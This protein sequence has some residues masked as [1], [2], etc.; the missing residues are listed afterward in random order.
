M[1]G[2][3]AYVKFFHIPKVEDDGVNVGWFEDQQYEDG[4]PVAKVARW[5]EFG[6]KAGIPERPFMRKTIMRHEKEWI[7][8][9]R[10][11]IQREI[12]KKKGTNIDRALAQFGEE[13]KG[14]IQSTILEGGFKKNSDITINGG[15]IRRKGGK[16]FYVEG[17]GAGKPPLVDTGVMLSSIQARTDKELL[18]V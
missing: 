1:A 2:L 4:L 7:E 10:T 5:N 14:D 6:T 18:D 12:D 17:K 9:L 13:V 3:E 16:A 11:V 15:W 8:T